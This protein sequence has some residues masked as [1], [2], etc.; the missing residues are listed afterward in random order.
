M[1][2]R[3]LVG[4]GFLALAIKFGGLGIAFIV[5]ILVARFFGIEAIGT[6]ALAMSIGTIVGQV[7]CFGTNASITR[8][9]A[10]HIAI[11][12]K[13]RVRPAVRSAFLFSSI[14]ASVISGAIIL[15][16]YFGILPIVDRP[17]IW[18]F[19]GFMY[20][21]AMTLAG[22]T[23]IAA[24]RGIK[25]SWQAVAMEVIPLP[26]MLVIGF[27][28]V[29]TLEAEVTFE[30]YGIFWLAVNFIAFKIRL[31]YWNFVAPPGNKAVGVKLREILYFSRPFFLSSIVYIAMNNIDVLMLGWL[32]TEQEIGGYAVAYRLAALIFILQ[33]VTDSFTSPR[34]AHHSA[35]KNNLGIVNVA[36][37]SVTYILALATPMLITFFAIGDKLLTIWGEEFY[38]YTTVL[39]ILAIAQFVNVVTGPCGRLLLYTDHGFIRN[40]IAI[41][42]LILNIVLNYFGIIAFGAVGAAYATAISIVVLYS[43]Y[44]LFSGLKLGKFVVPRWSYLVE[45]KK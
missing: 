44:W 23:N 40:T 36:S 37:R 25:K 34:L 29:Y 27:G 8:W 35:L 14:S 24:L 9:V 5:S 7:S 1:S 42:V 12:S 13:E 28:V 18:P 4:Q 16:V 26:V 19:A 11:E 33:A 15:A 31:L 38:P 39:Y 10:E 20:G 32:S 45:L 22:S 6:L 41:C 17:Q 43:S 30:D 2:K 21:T 3:K